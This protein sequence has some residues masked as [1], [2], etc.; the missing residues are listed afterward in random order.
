MGVGLGLTTSVWELPA[1]SKYGRRRRGKLG[2]AVGT[3]VYYNDVVFAA[4]LVWILAPRRGGEGD[5]WAVTE[6]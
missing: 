5:R 3:E 6:E 4:D 2:S 1:A